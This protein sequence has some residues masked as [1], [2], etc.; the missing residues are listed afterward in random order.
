[1]S[2]FKD[3]PHL[4]GASFVR[5]GDLE[6]LQDLDT[7]SYPDGTEINGCVLPRLAVGL[8]NQGSIAGIF[9]YSVQT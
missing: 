2:Y 3:S 6:A 7:K 1:M 8:T 4:S 9:G 5:I